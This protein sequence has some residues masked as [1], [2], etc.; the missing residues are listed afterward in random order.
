M[1]QDIERAIT[2]ALR[3]QRNR[4]IGIPLDH[5][6]ILR[7]RQ[8]SPEHF[9]DLPSDDECRKALGIATK[10]NSSAPVRR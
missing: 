6:A 4:L 1:E 10:S 8:V 7:W 5:A 2:I 3:Q 9:A